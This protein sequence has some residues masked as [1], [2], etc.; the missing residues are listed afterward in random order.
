M[1][2]SG[3][4][5]GL[6]ENYLSGRFQ[7]VI[8]NRQTSSWRLTLAGVSQGSI[9]GPLLLLICINDLPNGLKTNAKVSADDTSLLAMGSFI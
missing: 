3:E 2:I 8:S 6:I 7:R 4:L 5:Y 9:L 1:G